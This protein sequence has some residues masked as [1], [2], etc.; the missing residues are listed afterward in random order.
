MKTNKLLVLALLFSSIIFTNCDN[1]GTSTDATSATQ[2]ASFDF[3]N[4][5]SRNF[6]GKIISENNT[7]IANVSVSIGSRTTITNSNGEFTLNNATV[8]EN[9]AYLTATKQGFLGGSRTIYPNDA[10]NSVVIKLLTENVIATIP[11][12]VVSPVTLPNGMNVTFDG[13]FKNVN[14]TAYTGNVSVSMYHLDPHDEAVFDKMPGNLIAQ[15]AEGNF[16]GLQT[17]G[18]VNVELKGSNGEKLQIADGHKAKM[19]MPITQTQLSSALTTIPLW[20]FDEVKG[21]WVE[22]G[23]STR[24]GNNYVTEVS[25]F[26]WWNN[27][28]AYVKQ[29][30]HVIAVDGVGNPL[31]GVRIT[32]TR[33]AGSTGDVLINLGTTNASGT[34]TAL[35]PLTENLTFR[36]YTTAGDLISEQILVGTNASS[37]TVYVT[38]PA[39]NKH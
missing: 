15:N 6:N 34:L 1:K 22:E 7:P 27:D 28:C 16:R 14:G 20:H 18:M 26:S 10:M 32:L 37:R 33:M 4:T 38:L 24:V 9:F 11:T 23:F 30:L 21:Y 3:G 19:T 35:V 17:F 29:T 31:S 8:K 12:G 13:S 39:P 25:H 36:A 2:E 5:V